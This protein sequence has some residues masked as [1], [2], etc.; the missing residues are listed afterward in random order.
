MERG[1]LRKMRTNLLNEIS[2]AK[3]IFVKGAW[4]MTEDQKYKHFAFDGERV[5]RDVNF[6]Q[7][8]QLRVQNGF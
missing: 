1:R 3:S 4:R 5:N 6:T 8:N 7:K 2:M